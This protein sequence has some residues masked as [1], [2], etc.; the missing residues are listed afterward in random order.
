MTVAVV[1]AW[2]LAA[3]VGGASAVRGLSGIT[4][5]ANAA[6]C[7]L[8]LGASLALGSPGD[9]WHATV[10]RV[11]GVTLAALAALVGGLTLFEN[12]AGLDLGIDQ[13]IATEPEG[14]VGVVAPNRMGLPAAASA[15]LAGLALLAFARRPPLVLA[16][17]ALGLGVALL[18]LVSTMGYVYQVHAFYGIAGVTAI[19]WPTAACLLALGVGLLCARPAEGLMRLVTTDDAGGHL[20]RR[21]LAPTLLVP[22]VLGWLRLLGERRGWF[23][24]TVGTGLVMLFFMVVFSALLLSGARRV[25]RWAGALT[26]TQAERERLLRTIA[27]DRERLRTINERLRSTFDSAA[28]GIAQIDLQT[29]RFVQANRQFSVMTG[30]S[31]E[32]LQN[33]TLVDLTH[34][35][36]RGRVEDGLAR[37]RRGEISGAYFAERRY[38]CAD[39]REIDVDLHGSLVRDGAD[40]PA[41]AMIV[42]IDVTA[43]KRAERELAAAKH[44]A[45]HA[46]AV[47]EEASR[48][49]DHFLSVLSHELR[50][51][52]TPVLTGISLLEREDLSEDG[53]AVLEVVLRNVELESR[54]I[55]DLLDLTRITRGKV[56]LDRRRTELCTVIDR[57]VEVCQADIHARRLHFG[58]DYGPRPYIVEVD[59]ARL[60]QVFWNLLKNAIKFTPS[61][62][63]IGLRCRPDDGHVV[64]E[65]ADSGIGI[66]SSALHT[67]FDAFAQ[68]ERSITRQFGGL[69]LGL[70]ISR[71]LIELHGGRI[72][73]RSEGRDKG[74]T[75][76][77]RLPM[78][79]HGAGL[80]SEEVRPPDWPASRRRRLRILLVEDHGDTAELLSAVLEFAGHAV[81]HAADVE[82]ALVAAARGGFDLL[83][84]DLGLP[85]RSGL[86]LM[87]E[88]RGRGVTVPGIALSGYGQ[89]HDIQAS[90]AAGFTEHLVKPAE[91]RLLLE[92]ISRV[93][94]DAEEGRAPR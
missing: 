79:S 18:G 64:V 34:A 73:A 43:R 93:V 7:L 30:Y 28:A 42:V 13:L 19:A 75:F 60:Q 26:E 44:G 65:V 50:T 14:A 77:V 88:L 11:V 8:L 21:L 74:A 62:G 12:V 31:Q 49:K 6:L 68:A 32:Q 89:E 82:N 58:V 23:D 46:L 41:E 45:D 4:I 76:V 52:L 83:V 59:G 33:M 16:G 87:R 29:G 1:G 35:D 57:A 80:A 17:Q 91:P 39:G 48:A 72:E 25:N 63:C 27:D 86:D 66:E 9:A 40:R 3:W 55:D 61:G 85:D 67:I 90:R 38:V 10:R 47:A 71:A 15:F 24:P 54:L 2:H 56:E 51:P 22:F 53:R 81:E 37:A 20:I 84:S 69:G 70:T 78:L 36:D 92:A 5:K 94:G